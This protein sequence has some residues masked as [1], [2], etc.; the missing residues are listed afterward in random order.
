MRDKNK[1]ELEKSLN[2]VLNYVKC[3]IAGIRNKFIFLKKKKID[4]TAYFR[5]TGV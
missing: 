1:P 5:P 2:F 3:H 4:E